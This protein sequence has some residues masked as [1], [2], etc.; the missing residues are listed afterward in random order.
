MYQIIDFNPRSAL[1]TQINSAT[2]KKLV[3]S[4][5]CYITS[6]DVMV[7]IVTMKMPLKDP[8]KS[9]KNMLDFLEYLDGEIKDR[10]SSQIAI[11]E[12]IFKKFFSGDQYMAYKELLHHLKIMSSVKYDDKSYYSKDNHICKKYQIHNKYIK[13]DD[14]VLVVFEKQ[15]KQNEIT[16]INEAKN[17]SKKFINTIESLKINLGGALQAE[18]NEY[19]ANQISFQQLKYRISRIFATRTNRKITNG[20]KVARVYHPFSNI[21]KVTRKHLNIKFLELDIT[22][23]QPSLLI[24]HLIDNQLPMDINY[25]TDC[26]DGCFYERF[27]D[28][29]DPNYRF[30]AEKTEFKKARNEAKPEIYK[31]IFFGFNKKSRF[32]KR[33]KEIYPL[34]WESLDNVKKSDVSLACILQ[35]VEAALFNSL[36][37]QRSK[38][39]FTLFD[40]IY[41]SNDNDSAD[42]I[43]KIETFFGERNIKVRIEK[44]NK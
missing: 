5:A 32:N 15:K 37:P 25:K 33:F 23:C 39:F 13:N 3:Q 14:Y 38:F 11:P 31:N 34:V 44:T 43:S 24:A 20:S 9:I 19:H 29:I 10:D 4:S 40:A 8:S 27:I 36:F 30:G 18:I 7:N 1:F 26:E 6:K 35:N 41:Y 28:L 2:I 16:V 17:I 22:N 21:S 12:V 42:L